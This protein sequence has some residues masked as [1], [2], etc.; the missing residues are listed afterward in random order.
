MISIFSK[1]KIAGGSERRCLEL[2]NSIV[3]FS[4]Y[5]VSILCR[6]EVFP[7]RLKADL[8]ERVQLITD[9]LKK[10]DYF[11]NSD[12]V[13]TVNTDSRDFCKIEY[14]Q[15]FLDLNRMKNKTMVFLFNFIVS[16]SQNL[17][18]LEELGIKIGII[19]TNKKFFEEID[20]KDKFTNVSHMPR[21][22]LE[23]PIDPS[24]Y[25]LSNNTNSN[26]FNIH[27]LS[28]SY[29]DKWND[30]IVP[31]VESLSR[32]NSENK[33]FIFNMMGVK[34]ELIPKL[35][36]FENV[37]VY[38]ESEIKLFD[39]F[40][41][42]DLFIFF[43]SYN[44]QEPWA[45]VIAEAMTCGLPILALNNSGGT[46]DQVIDGNNG[47]LCNNLSDF[48][49]KSVYLFTNI[50]LCK[51]MGRNSRIY[52]KEFSSEIICNKFLRFVTGINE[53]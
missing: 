19:T 25:Q 1:F 33:K 16:P 28:K 37:K 40:S 52:S 5:P 36:T 10:P 20:N 4:N 42:S 38:R 22:I 44:R 39:F 45:R 8:D 47:F 3:R 23:S 29:D 11:Y 2:A 18:K 14:W 35:K 41:D 50:E 6:E 34:N 30:D 12:I 24:K 53:I 46:A 17:Y 13:L 21:M 15:S 51:K 7:E 48:I 49:D 32:L 27:F 26:N 43:P 9:C 31:L